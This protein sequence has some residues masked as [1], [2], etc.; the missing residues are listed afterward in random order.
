MKK[1]HIVVNGVIFH[2]IPNHTFIVYGKEDK[3]PFIDSV[4]TNIDSVFPL[5]DKQTGRFPYRTYKS[6]VINQRFF[7]PKFDKQG[8]LK[9]K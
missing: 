1:L 7:A 6:L 8:K 4:E 2:E 9:L 3:I 5:T